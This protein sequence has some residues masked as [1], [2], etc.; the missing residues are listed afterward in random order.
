MGIEFLK[1]KFIGGDEAKVDDQGRFILPIQFKRILI[2]HYGGELYLCCLD[3]EKIDMYPLVVYE[4]LLREILKLREYDPVRRE[5][6]RRIQGGKAISLDSRGRVAIPP[7]LRQHVGIKDRVMIISQITFLEVW[8][9]EY[10]KENKE[11]TAID[12]DQLRILNDKLYQLERRD[13]GT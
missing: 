9:C 6:I 11:N 8:D 3:N 10:Y 5:F 7:N 4:R 13:G 12:E 2:D 1:D